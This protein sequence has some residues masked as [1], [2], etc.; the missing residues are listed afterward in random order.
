MKH[1]LSYIA[2]VAF[3]SVCFSCASKSDSLKNKSKKIEKEFV[4]AEAEAKALKL[5]L[6]ELQ[7]MP[8][9]VRAKRAAGLI[10]VDYLTL[11]DSVIYL[12]ISR[13]EALKLGVKSKFYDEYQQEISETNALIKDYN[14]RG[15]SIQL[16]D[17]A[18]KKPSTFKPTN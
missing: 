4:A 13:E 8:K 17:I 1:F 9:A 16:P 10:L 12:D 3:T 7:A 15:E 6:E 2:L 18:K 11:K 14:K 5:S